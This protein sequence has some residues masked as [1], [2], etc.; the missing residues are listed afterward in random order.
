MMKNYQLMIGG[1]IIGLI[2]LAALVGPYLPF[3]DRELS[4]SIVYRDENGWH[5]PPYEPSE[6]YPLGSDH[7]GV[8]ILS[9][10]IVGAKDTL[11]IL[12]GILVVRYLI[13]IPL[14]IGAYY[15]KSVEILLRCYYQVTTSMPPLFFIVV[16]IGFPM[17]MFSDVRPLWLI[18][19]IALTEVGRTGDIIYRTIEEIG[20]KSFVE[21]GIASGCTKPKLFMNYYWPFLQ[22]HLF[23]N[24]TFDAGRVLFLLAQLGLAG[25][26]VQHTLKSQLSGAYIFQSDS[27]TWPNLFMDF[28]KFMS[29][30]RVHEWIPFTAVGVIAITML[31]FYLFG[32]GLQKFFQSKYKHGNNQD[33]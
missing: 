31:G 12:L 6:T 29:S 28:E 26:F 16:F 21:S 11:L 27:L 30:M 13:A 15:M 22:S 8:D 2:L 7:R 4:E 14:G 19:V 24:I 23:T 18:L 3:V 25:I 5:M 17:I 10:V 9:K 32:E 20:K 33:L 1:F